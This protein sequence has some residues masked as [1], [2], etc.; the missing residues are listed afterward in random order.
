MDAICAEQGTIS[1][2]NESWVDKYSGYVIREIQFD[3]GEGYEA[4]GFKKVSREILEQE[5]G[6][7]SQN[8][9]I[10]KYGDPN[11]EIIN[12]IINAME[13]YMGITVGSYKEDV[14]RNTLLFLTNVM[15]SKSDYDKKTV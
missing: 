12:N 9:I 1:D 6:T 14:I 13:T 8:D 10:K 7:G 15:L 5:Y 2:D 4:S 3:T 11:A